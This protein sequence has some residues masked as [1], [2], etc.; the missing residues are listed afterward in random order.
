MKGKELIALVVGLIIGV[1]VTLVLAPKSG[2]ELRAEIVREAQLERERASAEYSRT[3]AELHKRM[4]KVQ[5][6]V[7][8]TLQ[9]VKDRVGADD[10]AE[11][12]A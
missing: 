6:D 10:S 8:E 2:E 12:E 3:M 1:V 4:D 11:S 9:H 5:S 7:Q